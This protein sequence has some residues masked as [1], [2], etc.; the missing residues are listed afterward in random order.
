MSTNTFKYAKL[1]TRAGIGVYPI[2]KGTKKV[3]IPG[4]RESIQSVD[5]FQIDKWFNG[6]E[7]NLGV[8]VDP[9]TRL[10][11]IDIDRHG[12]VDGV[13]AADDLVKALPFPETLTVTTAHGGTHIYYRYPHVVNMPTKSLVRGEFA[14]GIDILLSINVVGPGSI[15][16]GV[17]YA[18]NG[19]DNIAQA[20][21]WL[22]NLLTW[23]GIQTKRDKFPPN[24]RNNSLNNM[25]THLWANGFDRD[26]LIAALILLNYKCSE[27][28]P[29]I[30]GGARPDLEEILSIAGS[31]MSKDPSYYQ[32]RHREAQ[33]TSKSADDIDHVI[34]TETLTDEGNVERLIAVAKGNIV[35]WNDGKRAVWYHWNGVYWQ[36]AWNKAVVYEYVGHIISK[37]DEMGQNLVDVGKSIV[38]DTLRHAREMNDDPDEGE[39][40]RGS[41]LE[42]KGHQMLNMATSLRDAPRR[43]SLLTVAEEYMPLQVHINDFDADPWLL[44]TKNGVVDLRSGE[45]LPAAKEYMI[46]KTIS[47]AHDENASCP[48]WEEFIYSVF[49]GDIE[50]IDY[51]QQVV[52]YTLTGMTNEEKYFVCLGDGGNGKSVFLNTIAEILSDYGKATAFS[53]FD[54]KEHGAT[55][56]LADIRGA[57]YVY[58]AERDS[59][60]R[61]AENKLKHLTGG[62]EVKARPLYGRWFHYVPSYKIWMAVNELP[63]ITGTDNGT[64]RRLVLIDFPVSFRENPDRNLME[65]LRQEHAGILNW[66]IK[67]CL[68]WQRNGGLREPS[69]IIQ[70]TSMYRASQDI[71]GMFC[72]DS[73]EY[74]EG[75]KVKHGELYQSYKNWCDLH[76]H[77]YPVSSVRF[78]Q[79]L[80]TKKSMISR[81]S[82]GNQLVYDNFELR[83]SHDTAIAAFSI[84]SNE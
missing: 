44:G 50:M 53:T 66:M 37:L 19:V 73:L 52:G 45:L 64:W 61:L 72:E 20:P 7:N 78:G 57:R 29:E 31:V 1:L 76:G 33:I 81:R 49:D 39:L 25:G 84:D 13:E 10:L 36:E 77:K 32:E 24:A 43:H 5:E 47:V 82:A 46:S 68:L 30:P 79:Y 83:S 70:R 4:S 67:G 58:A 11:V 63:T 14:P 54:V 42:K 40:S 8:F 48:T 3:M 55:D 71:I 69:S 74:K 17:E 23:S 35:V 21:E 60:R 2:R 59:D 51:V 15:V 38:A 12:H 16:D 75:S 6:T 56:D 41:A 65:K 22:L 34:E 80:K 26:T 18:T 62:E 9:Q 27:H 28:N